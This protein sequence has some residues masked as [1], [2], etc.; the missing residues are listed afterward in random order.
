M[1]EIDKAFDF[2]YGH[3]VWTQEL[4]YEYS[5]KMESQCRRLHGHQGRVHVHLI[6]DELKEG[7]VTD[8]NHLNWL[9]KFID[10]NI[11]H[12]FI[13]DRNDPLFGMM[14]TATDFVDGTIGEIDPAASSAA[15]EYDESFYE[16]DFVP[17]SENLAKWMYNLVHEKMKPLGV[18]VSKVEWF[19]TPKSRSTYVGRGPGSMLSGKPR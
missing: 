16:V 11:D 4:D 6:A 7:M 2:C 5:G 1:W 8:F 10:D 17:T 19:E 14:K 12:K 15:R 13:I 9:K 18:I 3:R